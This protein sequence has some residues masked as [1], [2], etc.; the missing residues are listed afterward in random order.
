[1]KV[2]PVLQYT[3]FGVCD[4]LK[5]RLQPATLT[6]SAMKISSTSKLKIIETL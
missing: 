3:D 5:M 2:F 1:M 6:G 4:L